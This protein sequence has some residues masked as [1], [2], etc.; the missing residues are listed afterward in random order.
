MD[1]HSDNVF[2]YQTALFFIASAEQD[3]KSNRVMLIHLFV[4]IL[5]ERECFFFFFARTD[6]LI[7]ILPSPPTG[8]L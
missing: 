2:L 5:G 8:K 4:I 3:L 7:C 1:I 6:S